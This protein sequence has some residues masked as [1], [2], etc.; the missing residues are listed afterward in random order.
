MGEVPAINN[1]KTPYNE[2]LKFIIKGNLTFDNIKN[3][4]R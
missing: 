2:K 4:F 1:K 3:I